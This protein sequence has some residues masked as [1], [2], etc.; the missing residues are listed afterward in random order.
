MYAVMLWAVP[1]S[2][3]VN[4]EPL[5]MFLMLSPDVPRAVL[6][7]VP[8]CG[9][10]VKVA[11]TVPLPLTVIVVE[12]DDGLVMVIDPVALHDENM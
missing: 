5:I 1:L 12:L 9:G 7:K 11:V 4:S 8:L 2:G 6:P 3:A 10:T